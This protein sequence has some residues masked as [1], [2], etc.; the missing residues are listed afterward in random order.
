MSA[1]QNAAEIVAP[2]V[3]ETADVAP[4]AE[5]VAEDEAEVAPVVA[6][7]AVSAVVDTA[8]AV[9]REILCGAGALARVPRTLTRQGRDKTSRPFHFHDPR[10]GGCTHPPAE[11]CSAALPP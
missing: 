10:R 3:A 4:A 5:V 9:T 11:Q 1:A 7:V 6:A 2:T 8:E